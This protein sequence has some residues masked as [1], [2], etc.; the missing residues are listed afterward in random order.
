MLAHSNERDA[1][2][3]LITYPLFAVN[4]DDPEQLSNLGPENSLF[5]RLMPVQLDIT[6]GAIT[7]GNPDLESIM[8]IEFVQA[9]G[10]YNTAQSRS[11]LD[12]YRTSLALVLREPR[13]NLRHN[14]DYRKPVAKKPRRERVPV[15][16]T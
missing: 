8:V 2:G 6:T 12:E 5:R 3:A 16:T 11:T 1:L 10:D 15:E 4:F 9:N 13:C 7:V 14:P